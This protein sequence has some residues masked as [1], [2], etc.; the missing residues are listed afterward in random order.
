MNSI[1]VNRSQPVSWLPLAAPW[2]AVLLIA[3]SLGVVWLLLAEDSPLAFRLVAA[4]LAGTVGIGTL[5]QQ[6]R[7]R[8]RRWRAALDAYA[9][10]EIAYATERH[11]QGSQQ[12]AAAARR[13]PGRGLRRKGGRQEQRRAS[14]IAS[15]TAAPGTSPSSE[16]LEL[17]E[18]RRA[19]P[20]RRSGAGNLPNSR[21][22]NP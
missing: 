20:T 1:R 7:A 18:P 22:P 19:S 14:R 13:G 15:A 2:A 17:R 8:A 9:E 16:A 11:S 10:R 3:A 12:A 5:W 4:L 6:S 21:W